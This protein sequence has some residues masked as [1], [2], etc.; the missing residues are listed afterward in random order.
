MVALIDV[1]FVAWPRHVDR[2]RYFERTVTLLKKC[3]LASRHELRYVCSAESWS[4]TAEGAAWME[5]KCRELGIWLS[6][7]IAE[8][9]FGSNMNRAL[10]LGTGSHRF[11]V[12]DDWDIVGPLDLSPHCD[13][14]DSNPRFAMVRYSWSPR[15]H[16]TR[17]KGPV[18]GTDLNEI[19]MS[20]LYPYGDHPNLRRASYRDE[21][22]PYFEGGDLGKPEI[23]LGGILRRDG[24]R[25]AA[26]RERMFLHSGHVSSVEEHWGPGATI[27]HEGVPA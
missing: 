25:I 18:E 10:E 17:W 8:P 16:V 19:D 15:E 5:A 21:F 4:V 24:W 20:S 9:N 26:T 6:W 23:N 13:F 3:L 7:R 11:L 1:C 2:M 22:G 27:Q 12:L 14:L